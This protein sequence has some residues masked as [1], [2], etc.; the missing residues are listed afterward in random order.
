MSERYRPS[1][2]TEGDCF[3]SQWCAECIH[4]DFDDLEAEPCEILGRVF[5]FDVDHEHYPD[6]WTY[7]DAGK[8][9]CTEFSYEMPEENYWCPDTPDMFDGGAS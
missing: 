1:N 6:E 7:N 3:M 9:I 8:P 2:G 5:A 4:H